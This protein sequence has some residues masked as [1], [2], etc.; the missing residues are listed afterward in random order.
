MYRFL[1]FL[2]LSVSLSHAD[3]IYEPVPGDKGYEFAKLPWDGVTVIMPKW[4][5]SKQ[6]WSMTLYFKGKQ[7]HFSSGDMRL[8]FKNFADVQKK[9]WFPAGM[10]GIFY[11]EIQK[12]DDYQTDY[13]IYVIKDGHDNLFFSLRPVQPIK[14]YP[15]TL[16]ARIWTPGTLPTIMVPNVGM[17]YSDDP[18][19]SMPH[20]WNIHGVP[21]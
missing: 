20:H 19:E 9:R 13:E 1:I 14:Y 16:V 7:A 6:T 10:G 4:I 8:R 3:L 11:L 2:I 5:S 12:M 17:R 21:K 18:Q 15:Q